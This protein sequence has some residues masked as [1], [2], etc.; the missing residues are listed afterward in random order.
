MNKGSI[1]CVTEPIPR[2]PKRPEGHTVSYGHDLAILMKQ[3]C[4]LTTT[5]HSKPIYLEKLDKN[6]EIF[7]IKLQ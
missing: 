7:G 2:R 1:S 6:H 3:D 5:P 4:N